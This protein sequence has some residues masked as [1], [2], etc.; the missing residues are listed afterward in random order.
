MKTNCLLMLLLLAAALPSYAQVTPVDDCESLTGWGGGGNTLSLDSDAPVQGTYSIKSEG[1]NTERLRRTF[2]TPINTGIGPTELNIAY[3]QFSLYVSDVTKFSASGGQFE[4]TSSGNPD[5]DEYNWG[6]GSVNLRNGW[7]SVVL[8]LSA[9]GKQGNPN[10]GA[11][12]FFRYYKPINASESVIIKIDNVRFTKG[13]DGSVLSGAH[14]F[15][16]ADNT[17]GWSGSDAVSTDTGNKILGSASISKN[18]SGSSWFSFNGT[19]F[20]TTVSETDGVVKFWLFASDA[21]KFN[22]AGSIVFSSSGLPGSNEY[23]WN[24]ASQ[25]IQ[26]GWNHII[27]H[28]ADAVKT[29]NPNLAAINYFHVNQPLSAAITARI[30]EIEFYEPAPATTPV[31]SAN[32]LN[33]KVMFGYQ[34]WFGLPTDGSPTHN[35]W[36]HWFGGA[37]DHAN[38]TVDMW[39][40]LGD[41][42]PGELVATNMAYSNGAPAKLFSSYN[43]NTVDQHFKWM[44]EHEVDG[45]FQQRFLQNF[46]TGDSRVTRHFEKVIENV[47]TASLK[48][49]RVYAIMYDLSG[50]DD[51]S[52]EAV[53]AD[54]KKLVD[55]MGVTSESNY[56]WHKGRPLVALWGLGLASSPEATAARSD[57]LV[58]FFRDGD[59][60]DLTDAP[61]YRA[62]VMGGLNNDWRT[63][64]SEW[65]AV[66]DQLDVVSPWSVG[67]YNTESGANDFAINSVRPDMAY[68]QPKNIDYMPVIFPGFS[69]FN[70]QTVRNNPSAAIKNSIPRNGGSFLWQQSQNVINEG[71][72]MIYLAMFDE[73][74]EATSF[75]KMEKFGDHTPKGG[76]TWFLSLD[77]DGY[78]LTPDWYM[79]IGGYTKKVLAGK[80]TNSLSVPLYPNALSTTSG[81]PLPVTLV[82][83]SA[84]TEQN[85]ALLTWRTSQET[86][87]SHFEVQRSTDAKTFTTIGKVNSHRNATTANNYQY[88][89]ANL[90]AGHFYYRLKMVDLDETF[91]YS[92][93]VTAKIETPFTV[94]VFPNPASSLLTV[95]SDARILQVDV[96]GAS[97]RKMHSS[98]PG[99]PYFELNISNWPSGIYIVKI[100]GVERKIVKP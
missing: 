78:D 63:H 96:V 43:Y 44:R 21:T 88:S 48:Y 75:F 97:G 91:A 7:N 41:Y 95:K 22:G 19:P 84:K 17:A 79:A 6:T 73:V 18:G 99:Q 74:D 59:P 85:N 94:S 3:L 23:R 61:K 37:P 68:L 54:W 100:D 4:I 80:A 8:R 53:I 92:S 90:P 12:N 82:S 64:T 27:L 86:N 35:W 70:L 32:T 65:R 98:S 28:L 31:P 20:N 1:G 49:G 76:D 58:K 14:I 56:L 9:A 25:K 33:N 60:T 81:Q 55:E 72:N 24:V 93:I 10:L 34:G 30:D 77:A 40:Y 45:V 29:G 62:T 46:R 89:D 39:P 52:T 57:K 66:Y 51:T 38:A 5:T 26:N 16:A 47:Q 69:W 15:N 71:A 11:I 2:T 83:I 42:P 67:R 50:A 87:S 13:Y 36:L